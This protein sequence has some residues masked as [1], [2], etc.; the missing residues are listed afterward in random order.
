VEIDFSHR[1]PA[2][3]T[4]GDVECRREKLEPKRQ[5]VAIK[6]YREREMDGRR[7]RTEEEDLK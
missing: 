7:R 2:D 3:V 4:K 5:K 1:V 6:R